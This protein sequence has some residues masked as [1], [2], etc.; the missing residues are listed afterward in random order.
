MRMLF[1]TVLAFVATGCTSD[2]TRSSDVEGNADVQVST[3][4]AGPELTSVPIAE[5]SQA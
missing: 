2:E 5:L 3:D 1:A 4:S